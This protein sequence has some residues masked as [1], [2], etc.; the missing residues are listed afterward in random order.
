MVKCDVCLTER[1]DDK[2]EYCSTCGWHLYSLLTELG[3]RSPDNSQHYKIRLSW[4]Q[5]IWQKLQSGRVS[6]QSK[7]DAPQEFVERLNQEKLDLQSQLERSQQEQSQLREQLLH[8]TQS[9]AQAQA[10]IAQ[11]LSQ[12][13]QNVQAQADVATLKAQLAETQNQLYL[14]QQDH[15]LLQS[16]LD[17]AHFELK[18]LRDR[19]DSTPTGSQPETISALSGSPVTKEFSFQVVTIDP[20]GQQIENLTKKAVGYCENLG[21][22]IK[23]EMVSIP[24]GTFMMGSPP[25]EEKREESES[26][27]HQVAIKAFYLARLPVTQIQWRAVAELPQVERSLNPEPAN[28]KSNN[29]PIECVSWY[30]AVEFCARLAKSTGRSYRLP[31]E[32]EWEYAC[33]AGTQTPFHFGATIRAD[34]ANYDGNH[35]YANGPQGIYREYTTAAGSFEVANDFGLYD[36]HGNVWEWCADRWHDNYQSAP[37]DGRAWDVDGD[38][39]LRILRGGSWDFNPSY[40]RSA[41]RARYAADLRYFNISFRIACSP[42]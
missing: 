9:Q 21:D 24:A 19:S 33:R 42:A 22:G 15:A 11:L 2:A 41:Q 32:A 18:K 31:T 25:E 16:E 6:M 38:N 4:A 3:Q 28:S 27:L 39:R 5:E 29:Q 35:S 23:L 12:L 7:V 26:P 36:M 13:Q 40:C 14:L 17:Q 37:F 34:L 20:Q 8:L 30:D 1:V 10:Q